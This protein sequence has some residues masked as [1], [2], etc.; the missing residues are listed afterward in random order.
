MATTGLR[1]GQTSLSADRASW[2]SRPPRRCDAMRCEREREPRQ[3][4]RSV[5][6][7]R[8]TSAACL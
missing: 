4:L 6:R 2:H 7:R 5:Q 3:T 8:S 1:I